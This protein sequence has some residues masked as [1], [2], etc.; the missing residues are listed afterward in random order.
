MEKITNILYAIIG[1]HVSISELAIE[2]VI[3]LWRRV[4][5]VCKTVFPH[6]KDF[7]ALHTFF[8]S[9]TEPYDLGDGFYRHTLCFKIGFWK[10]GKIEMQVHLLLTLNGDLCL[11]F[12]STDGDKSKWATKLVDDDHLK[13]LL[14]KKLVSRGALL[15]KLD[16]YVQCSAMEA[17]KIMKAN[18]TFRAILDRVNYRA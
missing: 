12:W 1:T 14:E 10:E 13:S 5:S 18:S 16:M 6:I 17:E 2:E 7:Q 8:P 11:L 3:Y 15:N 9:L 4:I